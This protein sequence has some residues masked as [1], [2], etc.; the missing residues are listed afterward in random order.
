MMASV[1]MVETWSAASVRKENLVINLQ[2]TFF[3]TEEYKCGGITGD[4]VSYF[5]VTILKY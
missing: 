1:V 5:Q 3:L 4:S 2:I